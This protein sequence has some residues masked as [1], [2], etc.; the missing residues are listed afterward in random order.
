MLS[1]SS[2]EFSST[3]TT[4][5]TIVVVVVVVNV[6]ILDRDRVVGIATR[7]GLDSSEFEC[8]WRREF[9]ILSRPTPRPTKSPVQCVASFLNGG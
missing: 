6:V 1:S 4:T 3:S 5:T 8:R 2:Q 9:Y 7:Y